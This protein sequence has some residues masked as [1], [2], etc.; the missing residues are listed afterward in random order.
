MSGKK[1]SGSK[2]GTIEK[3]LLATAALNLLCSVINLIKIIIEV[4]K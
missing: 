4:V 1:K 2:K 3:L